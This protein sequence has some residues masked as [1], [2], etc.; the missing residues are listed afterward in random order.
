MNPNMRK[1]EPPTAFMASTTG[2]QGSGTRSDGLVV[3]VRFR[4]IWFCVFFRLLVM[5][6][7]LCEGDSD[8]L[9]QHSKSHG[10]LIAA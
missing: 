8:V 3:S 7:W 6:W 1:A 2:L 5:G 10:E 4:V 9:R